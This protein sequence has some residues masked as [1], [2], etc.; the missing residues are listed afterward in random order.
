M[1]FPSFTLSYFYAAS[2]AQLEAVVQVTVFQVPI[3]PKMISTPAK[4]YKKQSCTALAWPR[5]RNWCLSFEGTE[6]E[7]P[8]ARTLHPRSTD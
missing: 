3:Y 2:E 5:Q 6:K 8:G 7:Y 1:L 4:H